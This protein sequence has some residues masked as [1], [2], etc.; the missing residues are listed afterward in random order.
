MAGPIQIST[1]YSDRGAVAGLDRVA[2]RANRMGGLVAKASRIAAVGLGAVAAGA[3]VIAKASV[4]SAS[5]AQQSLGATETVFGK[6][7]DK[8]IKRS[9]Q[10]AQAIGLSANEYRE[11]SNV[12]GASLNGAG[13]P[14][15][16]TA[17]LTAQLNK[18]AADM[19]A[20]FGGTTR[21][22]IGSVSSL[23]RGEADPIER[24]G[25]SIK[26]SDVSARLAAKGLD[27]LTG[28]ALKQAEMQERLELLME[29]TSR[30]QGA[31]S[32]ESSTLA[33]Q[34]QRLG[35]QVENLKARIGTALLPILTKAAA[36]LNRNL[37]PAFETVA[38]AASGLAPY[39]QQVGNTL[40][41]ALARIR[42]LGGGAS[43]LTPLLTALQTYADTAQNVVL[44]AVVAVAGYL[45]SRLLPVF[46]DV[47]NIIG[48]RVIP[49]VATLAQF[50]YGQLV[51]A[52]VAIAGR[53]ATK[54]K[55]VF[56]QLVTTFR[57]R[58]L[59]SLEKALAKFQ[60]Y[61]PTI[62]KIVLVVVKVIGKVL[63]FA[64]AIL[65]KVLPPL[66]RLSGFIQGTLFSVLVGIVTTIVK[67]VAK[68]IEFGQS[69][70]NAGRK[71]AEFEVKV[72]TKIADVLRTIGGLPGRVKAAVAGAITWLVQTGRDIIQG[73]LN[74]I[75]ELIGQVT[76][77]INGLKDKVTDGLKDL[78]GKLNPL[79]RQSSNPLLALTVGVTDGTAGL[80]KVLD[81]VTKLLDGTFDDQ[82][83]ATT[84]RLKNRLKGE[85]LEK[86]IEAATKASTAAR[87]AAAKSIRDE[88]AALAVNAKAQDKMAASLAKAR[89][90]LAAARQ[91]FADYAATV[92][93]GVVATGN[94]T[95]LGQNEDGTV[96]STTLVDQLKD[97]VVRAQ[98]YAELIAQLTGKINATALQQII[99]A[100]VDGGLATAEAI[101][102]GGSGTI[103][104]INA[105]QAQLEA[106]AAK[107]GQSTA[108]TFHQAG[109]DAAAD[110]VRGLEID[111]AKLD[112]A[113]ERLAK[114]L[115]KALAK[116]LGGTAGG[117]QGGRRE[118]ASLGRLDP[119]EVYVTHR[120]T[121]AARN[122][123]LEIVLTAEAVD[124]IL[125]GKRVLAAADVAL[126]KGARTKYIVVKRSNG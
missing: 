92:K 37:T 61:Q 20:T 78:G 82:L 9:N 77:K 65:G 17:D 15:A 24:Y 57:S 106:Q 42:D 58:L 2:D 81:R 23:L 51:P 40:E 125:L 27:K 99:D 90:R 30:T 33:G 105:L 31:F 113:A 96:S 26:Q 110:L 103:A 5:N 1:Q 3:A 97:K 104:Q 8:V 93:A 91:A 32:R 87:K 73:L 4:D 102:A 120:A 63:E 59:P 21:E 11:L 7:A 79:G 109:V 69:L 122:E 71:V 39:V 64:A 115:R 43:A 80:A 124:Q 114:R 67:V 66:I 126:G 117:G 74:G 111:D 35:A 100:G 22:A 10:A 36:F 16:K 123:R 47:A 56:D 70:F 121:E 28:S 83:A 60:Q 118:T 85:K 19:A 41:A 54:L 75:D 112:R 84:K 72:A 107:L 86:A 95:N 88:T 76:D 53:V 18:R 48:T 12:V 38:A 49:I 13:V 46:S 68:V 94:I 89:D 14:L 55:P 52:V 44:P 98:R 101:A 45:A 25:V 6:F 50:I 34:Q 116:A 62:Q 29:K 119:L 108:K